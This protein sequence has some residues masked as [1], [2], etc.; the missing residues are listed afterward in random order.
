MQD[1]VDIL[2]LILA[3]QELMG[4]KMSVSYLLK[5]CCDDVAPFTMK[6]MQSTVNSVWHYPM[7]SSHNFAMTCTCEFHW[8]FLGGH[9]I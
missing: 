8:H 2:S 6:S 5:H 7:K 1:A 9:K 3:L 4:Q